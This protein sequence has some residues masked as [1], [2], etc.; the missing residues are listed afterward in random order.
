MKKFLFALLHATGVTRFSAWWHRKRVVF[1]CYHGVTQRPTR[2]PEDP[3]GLHVNARRFAMH[4]DFLQRRYR[5]L[6]LC[7]YIKAQRSGRALPDYSLV[8]NG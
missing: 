1:L 2:S 7:D 6:T 8:P 3:Q 4:L 5:I